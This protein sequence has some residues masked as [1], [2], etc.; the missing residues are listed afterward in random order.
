[1]LTTFFDRGEDVG[2]PRQTSLLATTVFCI[3]IFLHESCNQ[4]IGQYSGITPDLY[5][6]QITPNDKYCGIQLQ[7]TAFYN[8]II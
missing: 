7:K 4:Y 5:M 2:F 6:Y 3:Y 1:M 8:S